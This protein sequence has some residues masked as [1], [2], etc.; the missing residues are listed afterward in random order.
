[1]VAKNTIL[2]KSIIH[3]FGIHQKAGVK[4]SN[5]CFPFVVDVQ[6]SK[7]LILGVEVEQPPQYFLS[8]CG[9]IEA[10]HQLL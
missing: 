9:R 4:V 1:M 3:Q 8:M 2:R 7:Q 6:L 5:P 10:Q